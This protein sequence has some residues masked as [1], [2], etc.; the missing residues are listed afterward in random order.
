MLAWIAFGASGLSSALYGP[1]RSYVALGSHTEFAPL[2]ALATSASVIVISL[3]CSQILQIFP[4]GGGSYKIASQQLGPRFGLVSGCA[5]V[6]DY[7]L[8]IAVSLASGA[9]ALFSLLPMSAQ[10]FKVAAEIGTT[11]LLVVLN[12]RGLQESVRFLAPI[13]I[14]F[15]ALHL[16]LIL[17]GISS[18]AGGLSGIWDG[19]NAG[20][21]RLSGQAG[22]SFVAAT[23]LGSYAMGGSTYSG[24]E[25]I[26]N[27]VNLLAEPRVR[28]GRMAMLYIA[29]TLGITA[30]GMV[31]LY[32][33][34][35]V[36]ATPGQTLTAL[37]VSAVIGKL[38]LD[39]ASAQAL[40]VLALALEGAILVAAA[41]SILIFA[42]SLLGIMAADSWLPHRFR[43][44]SSR[45]V[46]QDG[47]LFVGICAIAILLWS[48]G[49]LGLLVV[50]YSI[51]VFL[52][53][54]L[55]KLGLLRYWWSRRGALHRAV[56]TA[57]IALAGTGLLIA[58]L[59][60]AITVQQKF[61]DGGWATIVLTCLVVLACLTVRRHYDGIGAQRRK[62]D[63]IFALT[64]ERLAAAQRTVPDP[65]LSTAIFLTTEH[66]GPTIHTLLWVQRLFPGRFGNM[67]FVTAVQV[68]A[69]AV[70]SQQAVPEKV[71]RIEHSLDQTEA[72][73]AHEGLH[74]ARYVAYGIDPVESLE[75]LIKEV[76]AR[77]PDSVCFA[78]TLILP[79]E[80]GLSEWL[81]NQTAIGLQRKL[82]LEGI[83][84]VIL[85]IKLA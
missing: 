30:G 85:P 33:L 36:R 43:G 49:E 28:T 47:V 22:W 52:C 62:L 83:P 77:Y 20:I 39:H 15:V 73:C 27:H 14:G 48:R 1:E 21:E 25:S 31:L 38:G 56:L 79:A 10:P 69:A 71:A 41:N 13:V 2:L 81:H 50:L 11:V 54:A 6:V 76:R 5:Q 84:L 58:V 44:L 72:F 65:R 51:N 32:S 3:A 37:A 16:F 34:E 42:P 26:S 63:E 82:H 4:T 61:F 80:R 75:R 23:L 57:R 59:V 12:L 24:V 53:L 74:T 8:T 78:N 19:A 64:P 40:L 35:S 66:W 45:L 60:L 55:T 70:G 67:V 9:D 29:L 46:R 68:D 7:V 18:E 17:F